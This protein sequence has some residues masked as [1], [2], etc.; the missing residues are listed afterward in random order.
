ME[1]VA[2][3]RTAAEVVPEV[4]REEVVLGAPA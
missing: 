4:V 3:G 2:F 1:D